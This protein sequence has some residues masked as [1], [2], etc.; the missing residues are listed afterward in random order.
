MSRYIF[1]ILTVCSF[2]AFTQRVD[3]AI[4]K[5]HS[6]Q[7]VLLEYSAQGNY[8]ASL[9]ANNEVLIW[10]MNHLK[11]MSSFKI[12]H[13][14]HIMGMK[15]TDD[16]KKLIIK[17]DFSVYEYE[18]KTSELRENKNITD[19]DFR[20][21]TFY[22]DQTGQ[23]EV[24]IE[25]GAIK[26]KLKGKKRK[27]YSLAVT[28]LNAPFNA[29]D[30]SLEK[31]LLVGVA[32]DEII[33][34]YNY[35]SGN[36][37]K[38]LRAHRSAILDVR[39]TKDGK[40][41]VTA[42]KDR[43]IVVWDSETLEIKS[44]ISS[45]V[46]Q[47][48]TAVF[49][50][51]GMRI[52]VGDELGYIYEIDFADLFPRVNVTR[53][54]LH[55]V[56]RILRVHHGE[57]MGYYVSSASNQVY[58]KE[59][60]A[61]KKPIASYS[62]RDRQFVHT[63][64]MILQNWFGTY[65]EPIGSVTAMD[66]S[67]NKKHVVY[68]GWSEIP[69]IAFADTEKGKTRHLY[70]TADWRQWTDVAFS[71]DSTFVS[72][73][74]S[75]DILFKWKITGKHEN[76]F[77]LQ[78]DT[79][80]FVIK[81]FEFLGN[82][83]L[84]LNSMKYGQFIYQMNDRK[85]VQTLTQDANQIFYRDHFVI[86]STPAHNLIFYDLNA[87]KIHHEFSGHSDYITDINFHPDGDKFITS[88]KDGTL[89]LWSLKNKEMLVTLIP[90]RNKEFVFILENNYYLITKGALKEIGFKHQG[91]Y[92]FPDQFDLKFNRPDKVLE[93]IGFSTPDVIEAYHKAYLKRLKKMNFTE[94]QLNGDFHL[95][96]IEI[97]NLAEL[98]RNTFDASVS[99]GIHA[100]DTKYELDRINVWINE[101]EVKEINLKT[102]HVQ[103]FSDRFSLSLGRGRNKIEVSVLNQNGVESYK[104]TVII[105]SDAGKQKPDLYVL[106]IGVSKYQ[107]T[108]F[109]LNYAAKDALDICTTMQNSPG[110]SNVYTK[111][112]TDEQV[113]LENLTQ[114][115]PF[116]EQ[117]D[118]N[119]VVLVFVAG[120]G[121]LDENFDYYFASHD[122][123][124]RAPE[125]RGIPYES[126][127][128]LLDKIK[129][130]KKLL[131]LDTCHS[132]EVDKDEIQIDSTESVPV[133]GEL[134]F[135]SAGN[136]VKYTDTPFGL[137][138]INEL[139]K[140][141]FTDL[142]RGTGATVISSSGG[143][144][145]SIE[146]G[147][148]KNGLFTYCLIQGLVNGQ[149]DINKDKQINVS[150]IQVYIRDEVFKLSKGLQTPTSR[151]QNNELDYRIW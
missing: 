33:Y 130:L 98:S 122:I 87:Q 30:V 45:N 8:L 61:A 39:F 67:P 69:N 133:D 123:D 46:F 102:Q 89:K 70:N 77:L 104:K 91:E 62:L 43:S 94:D 96:S 16:E 99:I 116:L 117:A 63:K 106:A 18:L 119:D 127:E 149:A 143:V 72:T 79:L 65:Q 66:V 71:S 42:G 31:N 125:K 138:S 128:Y 81:N 82:D 58:Y 48:N 47:K 73:L 78:K 2:A 141:L 137:K 57:K 113:T 83:K 28:Y 55:A 129:A 1:I 60:L 146:G 15:F 112:L 90:F 35:Q 6:D 3:L 110:F 135:R 27:K 29:V 50:E 142:R 51:D 41:F 121:V 44:R 36:K 49:S 134:L 105:H 12:D 26:K 59:N 56:N 20:K 132:G 93:K 38:E 107:Q 21:K 68:T 14:D 52:Y 103:E 75:S 118:I 5:G 85:L 22:F 139:T 88:S 4:Q 151:I 19:T 11:T 148:Y 10:E 124:F 114:A 25:N 76:D 92:F 37:I 145:L 140:T 144:E 131:F 109:N 64:K 9:A 97:T 17:T 53:P 100:A 101:V 32:A 120:H 40:Y 150:E 136:L 84:W 34:V 13:R 86:V 147:E 80:P 7:I 23:Y 95:P 54:D 24:Y 126:I 115:K 111:S 74:D 108:E